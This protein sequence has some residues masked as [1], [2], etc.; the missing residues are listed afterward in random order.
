MKY[1]VAPAMRMGFALGLAS[2]LLSS[3]SSFAAVTRQVVVAGFSTPLYAT[4]PPGDTN[5]LFVVERGG[6]IRIINLNTNTILP[7]AFLTVNDSPNTNVSTTGEGGLLSMAFHP[8]YATNGQFFVYYT[9]N[10]P[11]TGFTSR[12]SRF[13]VSAD[14]N[15]AN[16]ASETVFLEVDRPATNHNGGT[17]AF[18]PGDPENYL[19]FALGDSGGG[20]DPDLA[21][22][23][24]NSKLGKMLRIDVDA[25]PGPNLQSP[26]A[27]PT[28]P[29]VGVAGDDLIWAVGLRN[30]FRWSFDRWTSD[31]YIGDVGQD[32][33][34]EI[35]FEAA[36]AI[37]GLNYGWN[38]RE[39][40]D[41]APCSTV[42]PTLPGMVEPIHTY[43]HNGGA[44]SVTGGYIYRG[45]QYATLYG[46]YFF[47]DFETSLV[48]SFVPSSTTI[49]D[50]QTHTTVLNPNSQGIAG[51]GEDASGRLYIMEFSGTVT[52]IIDPASAAVADV[53]GDGVPDIHETNTGTYVSPT[54]TGTNPNSADSDGDGFIDLLEIEDDTNPNNAGSNLPRADV[55]VQLGA[56]TPR[57]GTQ[58]NPTAT[59]SAA[60][61]VVQSGGTVHFLNS[62]NFDESLTVSKAMIL[63]AENGTVR[64]GLP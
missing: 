5:R 13:T 35:D 62:G 45:M 16:P 15:V 47:A 27:P 21:A 12:V 53:D 37:G 25:G 18:K 14:P 46:R 55:Y 57:K 54:N 58:S 3:T 59:L 30:P 9:T 24:I 29:F 64:V 20:C 6:L 4:A 8:D 36:D 26:I 50:L 61:P 32:T 49:S 42:S 40:N 41:A 28:N 23:N 63:I 56:P 7:T 33:R 10:L 31:M 52:R 19:Y 34:E 39:G 17:L 60:V 48:A 38:A 51:F 1:L 43:L 11:S 2:F 22:Q 44:R